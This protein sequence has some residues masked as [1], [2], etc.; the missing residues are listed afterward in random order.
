MVTGLPPQNDEIKEN[1]INLYGVEY[2]FNLY[3]D[4]TTSCHAMP[5]L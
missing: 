4:I 2:K 1:E 5:S 3:I